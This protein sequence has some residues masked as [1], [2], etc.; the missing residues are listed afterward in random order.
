[1]QGKREARASAQQ[2]L[3]RA[4]LCSLLPHPG[5]LGSPLQMGPRT[6]P[7]GR[8]EGPSPQERR[9]EVAWCLS[10]SLTCTPGC[11]SGLAAAV[12]PSLP[13]ASSKRGW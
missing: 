12:K 6:C 1:M 3:W 13:V 8:S 4:S 2:A 11:S 9:L 7:C 5:S 10:L